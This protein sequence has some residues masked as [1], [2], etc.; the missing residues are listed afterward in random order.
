MTTG[1]T[2]TSRALLSRRFTRE[3][4]PLQEAV[5]DVGSQR[6]TML[7]IFVLSRG[8]TTAQAQ[9][10]HWL[11]FTWLDQEYRVAVQRLVSFCASHEP[12]PRSALTSDPSPIG[13]RPPP[14]AADCADS[15][16]APLNP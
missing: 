15:R 14:G 5:R 11:E 9:F 8:V 6:A 10:E 4:R 16:G 2:R 7:R 12:P 3:I 13:E 1:R